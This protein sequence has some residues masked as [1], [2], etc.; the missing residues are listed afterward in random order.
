M[1]R[2]FLGVLELGCRESRFLVVQRAFH[3]RKALSGLEWFR[4]QSRLAES[5]VL[6]DFLLLVELTFLV[7]LRWHEVDHFRLLQVGQEYYPPFFREGSPRAPGVSP[8][9]ALAL[10]GLLPPRML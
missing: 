6:G 8:D 5:V 7:V 2:I 10:E 3:L 9:V 4:E 1:P